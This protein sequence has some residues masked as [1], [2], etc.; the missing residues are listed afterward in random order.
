MSNVPRGIN[1]PVAVPV[2]CALRG[3]LPAGPEADAAEAGSQMAGSGDGQRRLEVL[4]GLARELTAPSGPGA[5]LRLRRRRTRR[6]VPYL[7][8]R[9]PGRTWVRVYC[10]ASGGRAALITSDGDVI[11]LDAGMAEAARRVAGACGRVP[12]PAA[13]GRA[14]VRPG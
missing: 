14:A 6:L 3:S 5:G 10:A 9:A 13:A 4:A 12:G 1:R 7:A 2:A 11:R 8:V